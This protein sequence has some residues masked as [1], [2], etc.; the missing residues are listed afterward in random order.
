MK[1]NRSEFVTS[2]AFQDSAYERS[3]WAKVLAKPKQVRQVKKA[4][5]LTKLYN[6]IFKFCL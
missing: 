5:F 4:N 2:Q 1:T 6:V 3:E